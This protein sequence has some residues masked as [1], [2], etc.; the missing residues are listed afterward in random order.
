[1]LSRG[2]MRGLEVQRGTGEG[3]D[4]LERDA[5]ETGTS[6]EEE[7]VSLS[8]LGNP[9]SSSD[10]SMRSRG[11]LVIRGNECDLDG[12]RGAKEGE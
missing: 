12:T 5:N 2:T 4:N 3:D 6:G 8:S 7:D 9:S 10:S 1:M 11:R